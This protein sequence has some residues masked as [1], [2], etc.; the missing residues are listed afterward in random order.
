VR[1]IARRGIRKPRA[2]LFTTNYDLCFE[3]AA[4]GQQFVVIDGFSHSH[5]Q[6][7]DR[8][9]FGYDIVRRVG[10][11][12]APDYIENVF[13]L[14][15]L[16]GSI[17]WRRDGSVIRRSRDDKHGAPVLIYPRDSKYQ[18]AFEPPYLDMMG[19]VSDS[20]PGAR[21][22]AGHHRFRLQR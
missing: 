5:P 8:A 15:K 21:H 9:H 1:K 12:D 22:L 4:Q 10:D 20:N 13:H 3:T 14:Y 11:Q 16:H 19:S 2:K 6:V 18:Q 7:Y 17:D